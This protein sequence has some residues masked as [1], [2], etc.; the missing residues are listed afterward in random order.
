VSDPLLLVVSTVG[1]GQSGP[2]W[3]CKTLAE[4]GD[5]AVCWWHSGANL[6][7]RVSRAF[8]QRQKRILVPTQ[9]A[10]EHENAWVDSADSF[11]SAADVDRCMTGWREQEVQSN[12]RRYVA[13]VDIGLVSDPTV[14]G[15]GHAEP[16][17]TACV[18]RLET[19]QGSQRRPVQLDAVEACVL[20][21]SRR[22][23]L[24]KVK[25]ESWQGAATVQRLQQL[26]LP[27][28]LYVPTP[29]SQAEEW[30]LLAHAI[31]EGRL[32]LY[33][34]ARLREE[35][36]GLTVD[37]GPGGAKVVDRGKV[38]QDHATVVRMLVA[39]LAAGGGDWVGVSPGTRSVR[40]AWSRQADDF[41][42]VLGLVQ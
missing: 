19:F 22:F 38:H 36:L 27:V 34:H 35:L 21:L 6:S 23:K 33:P 5:P 10:R 1:K 32:L 4:G 39:M 15:V 11:V 24:T 3:T 42:H 12:G 37:V 13:A 14:V 20:D 9:Y 31:A 40:D 2:L 17:G 26:D 16:D 8:L 25:V 41:D 18:D 28:E 7:P 29:K 30:P